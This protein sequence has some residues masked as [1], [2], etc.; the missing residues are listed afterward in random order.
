MSNYISL[1]GKFYLA[2]IVAGVAGTPRHIGNVPDFEV[3]TDAEIIEHNE[4]MTGSRTVDF[5]MSKSKSV[6]FKGTLEEVNPDNLAYILNGQKSTIAG[7]TV[8]AE[9]LGTVTV[10][11]EVELK[12]YNVSAVVIKDSTA[13][14]VTVDASKYKLDAAFGTVTFTDVTGLTMPLVVD[15]TAGIATGVTINDVESQEYELT[16][17]G[18]NTANSNSKVELKLWRTKKDPAATFP[19]IHEELGSYEINGSALSDITRGNDATL[20]LYGRYVTIDQA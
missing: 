11:T 15:Y 16:F 8:V 9:S 19:L 17:R 18:V 5:T 10:G 1:Q 4:S 20:G 6:K 7:S 12:G 13:T 14:P 3:S 2:P